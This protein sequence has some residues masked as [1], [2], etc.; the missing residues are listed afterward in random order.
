VILLVS[1]LVASAYE[2]GERVVVIRD[3]DL[4]VENKAVARVKPWTQF[5]IARKNGDWLWGKKDGWLGWIESRNVVA[6]DDVI[7]H[8]DERLSQQPENPKLY[9]IRARF[10]SDKR[11]YEGAL[12]DYN[13]SLRINGFDPLVYAWR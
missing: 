3:A 5:E 2:V 13:E 8:L 9:N 4:K 6:I 7:P 11:D 12:A 1:P 10:K